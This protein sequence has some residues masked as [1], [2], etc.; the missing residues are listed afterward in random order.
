MISRWHMNFAGASSAFFCGVGHRVRHGFRAIWVLIVFASMP[1]C[2]SFRD[3]YRAPQID[4]RQTNAA[5]FERYREL[6]VKQASRLYWYGPVP[7]LVFGFGAPGLLFP[8]VPEIVNSQ[9]I[10][11]LQ[12]EY[13]AQ[14]VVEETSDD[15]L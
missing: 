4:Y 1:A 2:A 12:T 5:C 10:S 8:I 3:S 15:S 13:A 11:G 14:C 7:F 6:R 9:T